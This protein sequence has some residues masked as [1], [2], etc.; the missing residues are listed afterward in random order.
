MILPCSAND[1]RGIAIGQTRVI[2]PAEKKSES[3]SVKNAS[4]TSRYL[5]QSWVEDENG[6][7]TN[8]YIVTPP[9]YNSLPGDE[10]DLKIINTRNASLPDREKVYYINIKSIP[11]ID[12]KE[13][14]GK[15]VMVVTAN[16]RIKMFVRPKGLPVTFSE[17]AGKINFIYSN[18]EMKAENPTPYYLTL[19][20][21]MI[22]GKSHDGV[23]VPPFGE[24]VVSSKYAGGVTYS[25]INDFGGVTGSFSRNVQKK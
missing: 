9:I 19:K 24:A 1:G 10:N 21:L 12:K 20:G 7:K 6:E 2:F 13:M 18:K 16:A 25:V 11:N 4:S 17:A 23:M 14:E 15:S 22:G 5:I 3:I 8:D